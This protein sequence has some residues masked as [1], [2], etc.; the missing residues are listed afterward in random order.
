MSRIILTMP[1]RFGNFELEES[2]GELRRDGLLIKL[3]PRQFRLLRL[4]ARNSGRVVSREEIQSE[5]WGSDTFVDFQRNLNVCVAQLRAALHDD[6]EAPRFIQTMPRRGYRF[7]LPV[8]LPVELPV[9]AV[10][11]ALPTPPS[12]RRAGLLAAS[13]AAVAICVAIAIFLLTRPVPAPTWRVAVLPFTNTSAGDTP[14]ADGIASEL[15]AT[16]GSQTSRLSVIGRASSQRAKDPARELHAD[17][18]IEGSLR[19]E[20]DRLRLTASLV[21]VAD[22]VQI[23]TETFERPAQNS[24]ALQE[25]VAAR[26]T[27]G[28]L[29]KLFPGVGPVARPA[30]GASEEAYRLF[31]AGRL[32]EHQG[33]YR[34][35]IEPLTQAVAIS[36]GFAAAHAAIAECYV[37]MGR[38]GGGGDVFEGAKTSAIEALRLDAANAEAHNALANALFWHDWNWTAAAREFQSAIDLNPSYATAYH[39]QAFL[40]VV[41]GRREAGLTALRRAI[42]LDPLSVRVNIDAG[43]L[44]LQAHHFDEAIEQARRALQLEPGLR[45]AES[46][47]ARARALQG[48][49]KPQ[50]SSEP[51]IHATYLALTGQNDAAVA[52]LEQAYAAHSVMM[53]ELMSEPSLEKLHG[54]PRFQAIA[55]KMGLR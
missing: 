10:E 30:T 44:L 42:A 5:I 26:V 7:L 40:L 18:L 15:M 20:S 17:Y 12:R 16:L 4:L 25:D 1:L 46:C 48:S 51:F 45:E 11:P 54:D 50:D 2:S 55:A 36:P 31:V 32:L 39:D 21:R 29:A 23:W 24:F 6:S 53:V 35:A 47:M 43:W 3:T 27:A 14:I 22:S 41:T 13:L 49:G 9:A 37:G 38:T 8:E 28:V 19:R 52:S 34:A 33:R